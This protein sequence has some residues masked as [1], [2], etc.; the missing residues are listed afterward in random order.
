MGFKLKKGCGR[1]MDEQHNHRKMTVEVKW[2]PKIDKAMTRLSQEICRKSGRIKK[3]NM[4]K[5]FI[6]PL[7]PIKLLNE[8]I[9]LSAH[10]KT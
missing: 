1:A 7:I 6:Q 3:R 8:I 5:P 9:H 4:P 2:T 10:S